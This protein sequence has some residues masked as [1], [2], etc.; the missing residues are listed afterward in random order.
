MKTNNPTTNPRFFFF[1][2]G[3]L[4]ALVIWSKLANQ[5]INKNQP[6]PFGCANEG[7]YW[8]YMGSV[9]NK[10]TFRHRCHPATQEREYINILYP[11]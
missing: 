5:P 3:S 10:H 6:C 11:K 2:P 7:E 9:S 1:T 4:P 8:Q